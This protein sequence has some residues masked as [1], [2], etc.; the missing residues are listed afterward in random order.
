MN[1][2]VFLSTVANRPNHVSRSDDIETRIGDEALIEV[3]L[4][5][6]CFLRHSGLSTKL[7]PS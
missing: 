1:K 5:S 6:S 2:P 7:R 4:N 3:V